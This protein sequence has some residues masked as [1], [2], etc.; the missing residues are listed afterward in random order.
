MDRFLRLICRGGFL[1]TR[2][3]S[4]PMNVTV[5][6]REGLFKLCGSIGVILNVVFQSPFLFLSSLLQ[7]LA[8]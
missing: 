8:P 6:T 4:M 3:L 7:G 1:I 2:A 5:I